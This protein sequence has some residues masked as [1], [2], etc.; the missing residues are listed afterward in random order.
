MEKEIKALLLA[1]DAYETR[2]KDFIEGHVKP[3]L[4]ECRTMKE[5]DA[6]R[7]EL[8]DLCGNHEY[9]LNIGVAFA[10]ARDRI[11]NTAAK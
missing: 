11:R 5:V 1:Q 9:P 8:R 2:L 7:Q 4:S 10:F 3:R 6:F